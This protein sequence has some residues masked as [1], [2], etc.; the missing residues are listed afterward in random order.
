MKVALVQFQPVFGDVA[1]NIATADQL[2]LQLEAAAGGAEMRA[3]KKRAKNRAKE[4]ESAAQQ[5]QA[6]HQ[7]HQQHQQHRQGEEAGSAGRAEA[8]AAAAA[9]GADVGSNDDDDDNDDGG[10]IG[11]GV[12]LVILPEMAFAG[13]VFR[14]RQEIAPFIEHPYTGPTA[15]WAKATAK[16]LGCYVQV[17]YARHDDDSAAA[18]AVGATTTTTATTDENSNKRDNNNNN[19][20]NNNNDN[21]PSSTS[22]WLNSVC[23]AAP[24]GD[25]V[26][27]YDKHFLYEVDERWAA[28]GAAFRCVDVA[29]GAGG[30][31]GGGGGGRNG[32]NSESQQKQQPPPPPKTTIKLGFGIC[33]DVNPYRFQAPFTAFEFARFHARARTQFIAGSMAWTLNDD[34]PDLPGLAPHQPLLSTVSYWAVRMSPLWDSRVAEEEGDDEDYDDGWEDVGDGGGGAEEEDEKD[35]KEDEKEDAGTAATM[36]T[37][38]TTSGGKPPPRPERVI[39]AIANRTGGENGTNFCGTSVVFEF[40]RGRRPAVLGMLGYKEE[41]VLVVD[42]GDL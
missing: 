11:H 19:N 31:T 10:R 22:T 20:N 23:L 18:A 40:R 4:E 27:V 13:Y 21:G 12:D 9:A 5:K 42:V 3:A 28:E 32:D 33:M 38:T 16:R 7:Q 35:K 29:L 6:Q 30:G 17:G 2:L 26:H 8:A 15:S 14:N 39:M 24:T 25:V 37:T 34:D 41:G 36:A 1:A